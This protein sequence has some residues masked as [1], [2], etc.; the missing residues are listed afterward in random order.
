VLPVTTATRP[1]SAKRSM[2]FMNDNSCS[3]LERRMLD[4]EPRR[5]AVRP[6]T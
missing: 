5:R 3:H 4:N 2:V 1:L 6:D